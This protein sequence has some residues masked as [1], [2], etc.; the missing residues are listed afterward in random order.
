MSG[1][2]PHDRAV[3]VTLARSGRTLEVPAGQSILDA[4]LEAGIDVPYPCR[5]GVCGTCLT[6]VI[7]GTPDHRDQVLFGADREKNDLMTVCVSRCL[8]DALTLDL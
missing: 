2:P 1:A 3:T 6:G 4:L 7:A 5:D 8:G